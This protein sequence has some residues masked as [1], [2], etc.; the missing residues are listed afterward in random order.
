MIYTLSISVFKLL[1]S[2]SQNT[3]HVIVSILKGLLDIVVGCSHT[4]IH[5][6]NHQC[7]IGYKVAIKLFFQNFG[8]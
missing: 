6:F 8:W 1:V 7:P 5:A 4:F 3:K 2:N